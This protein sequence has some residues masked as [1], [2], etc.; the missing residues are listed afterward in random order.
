MRDVIIEHLTNSEMM[1]SFSCSGV[2]VY[3]LDVKLYGGTTKT[4]LAQGS[5]P[6]DLH[7]DR[8]TTPP[9][10]KKEMVI[11]NPTESN[12]VSIVSITPA[13]PAV[14][15]LNDRMTLKLRYSCKTRSVRFWVRALNKGADA[16]AFTNGS[17]YFTP[18]AGHGETDYCQFGSQYQ[19]DADAVEVIMVDADSSTELARTTMPIEA[20]WK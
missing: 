9:E 12:S 5:F 4:L 8:D 15:H 20:H 19:A 2:D 11:A 16:G 7:W 10:P 17:L 3:E 6:V 13:T 1:V 14:L 18:T